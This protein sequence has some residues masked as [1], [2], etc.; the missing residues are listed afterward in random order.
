MVQKMISKKKNSK[1]NP[2][3]L[4]ILPLPINKNLP[5]GHLQLTYFLMLLSL[6]ETILVAQ[7]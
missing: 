4:L 5:T 6:V 1:I 7:P 3:F 2:N